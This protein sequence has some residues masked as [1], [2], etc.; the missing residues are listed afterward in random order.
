MEQVS[1]KRVADYEEA[2]EHGVGSF[3][4]VKSDN[5][6][7]IFMVTPTWSTAHKWNIEMGPNI[8]CCTVNHENG[9]AWNGNYDAPTLTPSIRSRGVDL[10]EI[11]HGYMTDGTLVSVEH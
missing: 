9:W 7:A 6:E 3:W 11:W 10:I 5:G 4:W 2:M 8:V 1:C